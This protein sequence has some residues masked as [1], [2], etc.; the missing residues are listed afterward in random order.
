MLGQGPFAQP[1]LAAIPS[2]GGVVI[3]P[4]LFRAQAIIHTPIMV[5]LDTHNILPVHFAPPAVFFGQS[6]SLP[7]QIVPQ[8]FITLD[9]VHTP[10]VGHELELSRFNDV[11]LFFV[12][13][14]GV[15]SAQTLTPGVFV[16]RDLFHVPLVDTVLKFVDARHFADVALFFR[17]T[18]V[19]A[20]IEP[21][22]TYPIGT[23]LESDYGIRSS[24]TFYKQRLVLGH[25]Y[26]H[27]RR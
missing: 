23:G 11:A 6:V 26:G 12:P 5:R 19:R 3:T 17:P 27:R 13:T 4:A 16:S 22:Y 1:N 15:V 18:I 2:E 21:E 14:V 8:T 9:L 25:R 24:M 20:A 7:N 10:Q